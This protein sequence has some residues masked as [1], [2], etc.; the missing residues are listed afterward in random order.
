MIP[1]SRHKRM[2]TILVVD[3]EFAILDL[4]E[5][6]LADEGHVVLTAA[7]GRQALERLAQHPRP[8]LI[9]SDYMMPILNGASMLEAM[10]DIETQR[11]IP[12]IMMSSMPE[13]N[14]RQRVGDLAAFIRKPFNLVDVIELVARVLSASQASP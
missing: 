2:A 7:N 14:V 6:V 4:L 3:D 13:Q 12:C 5:M 10:R 8:D 9:I 1:A 11:D